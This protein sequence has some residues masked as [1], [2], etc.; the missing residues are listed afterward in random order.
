MNANRSVL[1]ILFASISFFCSAQKSK[2][3]LQQEKQKNLL[4][5]KEVEKIIAETSTNKKNTLG[6][7]AALNQRIQE[8]ESLISSIQTEINFLTKEIGEDNS[9]ITALEEDLIKMKEEYAAMLFA[10]QKASNSATRLTFYFSSSTFDQ[11]VMRMRYMNQYGT[12]RKL[13][14]DQIVKTQNQLASQIQTTEIKRNEQN[15]LLLD[16]EEEKKQLDGLKQKQKTLVKQLEKQEKQL[17]QEYNETKKAIAQLDKMIEDI[18]REEIAKA[19]REAKAAAAKNKNKPNNTNT[20]SPEMVVLSANFEQNKNKLGWPT[21]GFVAQKFGR[22]NHPLLK[23]IVVE[24]DGIRIQTGTNEPV[25][26]VFDGEIRSISIT[27]RFGTSIIIKHGTYFTIYVGL[28]QVK[29]KTGQK[30]KTN[31]E[32]GF[33]AANIEGISELRFQVFKGIDPQDPLLWLRDK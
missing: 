4:R 10:A 24:S 25:K 12:L 2:N 21:N 11:M 32:I 19:E 23:G 7:L 13:Q 29:V 5:I 14:A 18:I 33:V 3:Q 9:I 16:E 30:V 15:A 8:Q 31:E 22:Q 1:F 26:A 28:Q 27:P 6:E 17:R 20:Q